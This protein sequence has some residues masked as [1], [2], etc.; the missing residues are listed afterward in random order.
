MNRDSDIEA[1]AQELERT[2]ISLREL[3]N[4]KQNAVHDATRLLEQAKK[5]KTEHRELR[6]TNQ[7]IH[8][9]EIEPIHNYTKGERVYYTSKTRSKRG[10][11]LRYPLTSNPIGTV[12]K[13]TT[14]YV[15]ISPDNIEDAGTRVVRRIRRNVSRVGWEESQK[16]TK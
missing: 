8:V 10:K 3:D 13:E 7:Q 6:D 14:R 12:T 1:L 11:G 9:P 4:A 2:A 15:E 5:I 16:K